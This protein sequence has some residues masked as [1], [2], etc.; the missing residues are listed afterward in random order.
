MLPDSSADY[1]LTDS[2]TTT[3]SGGLDLYTYNS[4]SSV[5]LV[6]PNAIN[7]NDMLTITID[8]VINPPLSGSYSLAIVNPDLAGPAITAP[9]FP[10]GTG[11]AP[12]RRDHQLRWHGLPVRW[13]A[14]LWHPVTDGARRSPGR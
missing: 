5:T 13:P 10:D 12:G 14:C 1:A 4:D 9:V 2:T 7:E 3:G 6:V 11:Y 8:D